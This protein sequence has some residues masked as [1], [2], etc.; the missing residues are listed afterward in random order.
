MMLI[1]QI[2]VEGEPTVVELRPGRRSR[3][4]PA[5]RVSLTDLLS[6]VWSV[7]PAGDADEGGSEVT[8]LVPPDEGDGTTSE[9]RRADVA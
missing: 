1:N 9:P 7:G 4:E 3:P 2:G 6:A 8:T 5:S